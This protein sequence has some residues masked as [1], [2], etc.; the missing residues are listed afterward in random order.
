MSNG[1][2]C[3]SCRRLTVKFS[4]SG[5]MGIQFLKNSVFINISAFFFGRFL[6][7]VGEKSIFVYN[8]ARLNKHL[9]TLKFHSL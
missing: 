3:G 5:V 6:V 7:R 2:R 1:I 9:L 4:F 8:L